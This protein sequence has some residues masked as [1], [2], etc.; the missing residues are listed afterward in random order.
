MGAQPDTSTSAPEVWHGVPQIL[1]PIFVARLLDTYLGLMTFRV[2]CDPRLR[3]LIAPDAIA[4]TVL[5]VA[6]LLLLL[7]YDLLIAL[8]TPFLTAALACNRG[9]VARLLTHPW[10]YFLGVIS[11]SIYL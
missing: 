2:V 7:R 4:S 3:R 5:G 6:A 8:S 10:L 11:F 9:W 1:A